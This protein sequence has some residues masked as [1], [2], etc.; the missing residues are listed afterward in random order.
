MDCNM[1]TR[2]QISSDYS[3]GG[4]GNDLPGGKDKGKHNKSKSSPGCVI[5]LNDGTAAE[6]QPHRALSASAATKAAGIP[7][8]FAM[9]GISAD[10]VVLSHSELLK[11]NSGERVLRYNKESC[12][13][14][15]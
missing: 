14:G 3:C 5:I 12:C 11:M 6:Q 2:K 8:T 10:G 9:E 15:A 13:V 4:C 1:A 7:A